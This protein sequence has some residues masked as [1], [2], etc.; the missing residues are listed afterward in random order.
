M[1]KSNA[2]I[3]PKELLN[4]TLSFFMTKEF[5]FCDLIN[6]L[7]VLKDQI[8][9]PSLIEKH[10]IISSE[11]TVK[12]FSLIDHGRLVLIEKESSISQKTYSK[13]WIGR[14][15]TGVSP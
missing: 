11:S 5:F 12:N 10:L 6:G 2:V 4:I 13:H 8:S 14:L 3:S 1:Y 15:A 7:S 9:E